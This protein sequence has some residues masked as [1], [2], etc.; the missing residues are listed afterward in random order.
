MLDVDWWKGEED[1]R[2]KAEEKGGQ[3]GE[4][5]CESKGFVRWGWGFLEGQREQRQQWGNYGDM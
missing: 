3:I 5:E 1:Y 2:D 4:G